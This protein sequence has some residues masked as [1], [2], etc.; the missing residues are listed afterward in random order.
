MH[1]SE[2][3]RLFRAAPRQTIAILPTDLL[4]QGPLNILHLALWRLDTVV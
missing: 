2:R 4:V 1:E 3:G